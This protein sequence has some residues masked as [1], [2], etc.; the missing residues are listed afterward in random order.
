MIMPPGI[1]KFAL[2]AHLTCSVGWIGA[3]VAYLALGISAVTS[4]DTQTVRAAWLA[5][6]VTGWSAIVPMALAALLTGLVMSLGTTWGLVRHYWVLITFVLT[7][8]STVVLL[9]HMPTVS[10]V[11][12][13]ASQMDEANLGGLG[14][15]L[16]HP[17]AGLLV[18]LMITAL[19]VYKPRGLTPYGWRKQ[20]AQQRTELGRSSTME[21]VSHPA[22]TRGHTLGAPRLYDIFADIFFLGRRRATFQ[23]LIAAAGVYPRQRVLDVGCGTGYF[24]RLLAQAVGPEGLVVGIDPS[25]EMIAYARR[26]ASRARNCRFQVGTAQALPFPAEYFDV[27]VSSLVLHHVPDDLRVPALQEMWRVLRPG[28]TLLVAEAQLPRHGFGFHLLACMHGYD[29]MARMVPHLEPLATRAGFAEM[30]T[31]EAPPWLRYV[32]AIKSASGS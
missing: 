22:S 26:K 10:H 4:R 17:G 32:R 18:L 28:G 12:A 19:N 27:V 6:E 21:H 14:G 16:L 7:I 24:A 9:L 3:V 15:D 5:M 8:L 20:H 31:G 13:A 30:R 11:A 1:R 29:R 25:P 2:I 23:A